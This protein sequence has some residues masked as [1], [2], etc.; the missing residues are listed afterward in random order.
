MSWTE[1]LD[2]DI[3]QNPGEQEIPGNEI[4]DIASEDTPPSD[5]TKVDVED[6]TTPP[7]KKEAWNKSNFKKL[8]KSNKA[9]DARIAVLEAK[10]AEGA[11]NDVD[12]ADEDD[13]DELSYDK[14]DL[15]EFI[16]DTDWAA[17]Y[18]NQIKE[19]LEEFQGI[20][21][22]KALAFAKAQQPEE[23]KSHQMFNAKSVTAPKTKKLADLTPEEVANANLT[24]EQIDAWSNSQKKDVNPF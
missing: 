12:D 23:S 18:K 7:A 8:A 10:L 2:I 22:E 11:D 15:L 4:I 5:K 19:A 1:E 20:S 13:D 9:K 6:E 21:F 17:P 3:T 24:P 14:V 16:T